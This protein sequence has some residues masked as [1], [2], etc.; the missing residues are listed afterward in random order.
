MTL[1]CTQNFS[2]AYSHAI[3]LMYVI[4]TMIVLRKARVSYI[5]GPRQT[6]RDQVNIFCQLCNERL[7]HNR[8][9]IAITPQ[10]LANSIT[11]T[12]YKTT[13]HRTCAAQSCAT[14]LVGKG[15][16]LKTKFWIC[17]ENRVGE[18]PNT[19]TDTFARTEI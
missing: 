17:G 7:C 6:H 12:L 9:H 1:H 5:Y 8:I 3:L 13:P 4:C 19:R 16:W 14:L 2:E 10:S 11:M 18:I 15:I